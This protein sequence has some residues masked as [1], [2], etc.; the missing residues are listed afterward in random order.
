MIK[1]SKTGKNFITCD[2]NRDGDSFRSPWSNKYFPNHP[3][4][5]KPPS[6]LRKLEVEANGIFDI[7]RHLYFNSGISSVYFFEMDAEDVTQG[8]GSCWCVHKEVEGKGTLDKGQWD[9]MHVFGVSATKGGQFEY[10]LTSTVMV[11]MRLKDG[12][13]AGNSDLSGNL[14]KQRSETHGIDKV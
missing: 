8:F 1:D 10:K 3:E 9:S 5:F 14:T 7:Y 12:G 13:K 4:G 2:Y 6:A 11:E